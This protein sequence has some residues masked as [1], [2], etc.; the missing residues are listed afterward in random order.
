[1]KQLVQHV[2]YGFNGEMIP[3]MTSKQLIS[4]FFAASDN[5]KSIKADKQAAIRAN[6]GRIGDEMS[7]RVDASKGQ[8]RINLD[9][10][11]MAMRTILKL[12]SK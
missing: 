1:M 3:S 4:A 6:M 9:V 11:L 8:R 12:Q 2:A 10:H 5:L 7:D